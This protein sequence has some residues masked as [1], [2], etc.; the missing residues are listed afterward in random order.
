MI[1]GRCTGACVQSCQH[2]ASHSAAL[3]LNGTSCPSAV[4][5]EAD[6]GL[7]LTKFSAKSLMVPE[8]TLSV[9]QRVL[10]PT[11]ATYPV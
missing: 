10:I 5:K 9:Y 7:E 6:T 11:N 3:T 2:L 8:Q 1:D 4:Y